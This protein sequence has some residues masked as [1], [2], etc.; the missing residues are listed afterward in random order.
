MKRSFRL[1]WLFLV[2]AI[3]AGIALPQ[4]GAAEP[5]AGEKKG[6]FGLG[7]VIAFYGDERERVPSQ[8][9]TALGMTWFSLLKNPVE[10]GSDIIANYPAQ[11]FAID[12]FGFDYDGQIDRKTAQVLMAAKK[13]NP[14]LQVAIWHMRGPVA[15]KLAQ[16]Y[17]ESVDLVMM[18]TY[19]DLNDAWEIAFQLQSARLNGLLDKTIIGLGLGKLNDD[20]GGDPW[21]RTREELEQQIRL[22]RFVAP[23]SP[24]VGFFHKPS[25]LDKFSITAADVEELCSA[26][27]ETPTDGIGL[28]PELHGLGRSF[29]KRYEKPAIFCSSLFVMP[30]FYPGHVGPDGKWTN[31]GQMVEPLTARAILM[32]LG[33]QD[34]K[35]VIVRM[36]ERGESGAVWAKGIV[37]LP[38]RSVVAATLPVLPGQRWTGWNGSEIMEV[39]APGCEVFI[40]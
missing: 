25:G 5:A 31:W 24:G 39:E 19:T 28:K 4:A 15:P 27:P 37:D 30:N 38:A 10:K 23:E 20:R 17:R 34:A 36:R 14:D 22:I 29:T 35:D 33:E 32:N 3:V 7:T 18:E 6:P 9:F 13:K 16:A 1:T 12:E 21:T 2:Y 40:F 8:N 26:F 11:P